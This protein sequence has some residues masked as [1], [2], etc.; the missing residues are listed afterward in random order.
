MRFS[1]PKVLVHEYVTGGGWPDQDLPYGLAAEGF[2]MLQAI[3]NDFRMWG[4][5]YLVTTRD[6]RMAGSSLSADRIVNM[7]HRDYIHA[8]DDLVTEVDA[9]LVIAPESGGVLTGLS[10]LVEERG[11]V[12][13]GSNAE[14]VSVAGDKWECF[15]RFAGDNLLT[16]RTRRVS[17]ANVLTVAEEFGLPLVV[18]PIDGAGCEGV[19]VVS[20]S[21]SLQTAVHLLH[22]RPESILVQPYLSGTHA[23]VSLLVAET[24][25][26]PL[27]LNEQA[28]S[29]GLP[30][31]YRGGT[32]PLD[33]TQRDVAFECASR[34]VSLVPGL[35]GYVGVDLLL[36][37]K[38]CYT[39][40]INPRLTTSY[41]GLRQVI[42]I[43]LAEAIWRACCDHSLPQEIIL[44]GRA[45]FHKE[46]FS[47]V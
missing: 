19:S 29:P 15:C 12:V 28:V 42:N 25:V 44:T 38:Q 22:P 39:I 18:K 16:P 8:L 33:H 40:E 3:L 46:E 30:F 20:D 24:G 36:T 26:L 35:R 32:V 14:A 1:P 27:S 45:S 37:E 34:A 2:A 23:S 9:V 41:V 31:L 17:C 11:R 4:G 21:F 10:T 7:H 13:L 5:V 6:L 47:V 43:N